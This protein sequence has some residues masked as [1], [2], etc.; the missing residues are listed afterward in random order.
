M[1]SRDHYPTLDGLRGLAALSVLL[2]HLGHWLGIR[3]IATNARLAVDLFFCLSGYVV[4][5]AYQS[6]LE[7]GMG[8]WQFWQLRVLRL[9]PMILA[10]TLVSAAY[11]VTRRVLLHDL[12]I[13]PGELAQA[14]VVSLLCLPFFTASRALGG[15]QVFPLNG[16]QYTLFL[17]LAANLVWSLSPRARGIS[18]A[19]AAVAA[20]FAL[21]AVFGPGGDERATFWHGFPRVFGSY[22]TGVLVFHLTRSTN[23]L[24]TALAN[25][26]S[27]LT[28]MGLTILVT[29]MIFYWPTPAPH[30][31]DLT[32][33]LIV[34]P[35]LVLGGRR[36]T[37][38]GRTRALALWLGDISYPLYALHYPIFVWLNA[39]FKQSIS[40]SEPM[41]EAGV[42]F[43]IIL[44]SSW[45]LMRYF[46][47]PM[48]QA[49]SGRLKRERR[50]REAAPRHGVVEGPSGPERNLSASPARNPPKRVEG[51]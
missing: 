23:P 15:P 38:Q 8:K 24:T 45:I 10:G 2:F 17:E 34:A 19:A 22:Y 30:W 20:S 21:I 4:P 41:V 50:W 25:R 26:A 49:L 1:Q 9:W 39:V 37:L 31:I 12:D 40:K 5:L 51:T 13:F 3:G 18:F 28:A 11:L 42:I 29:A 16:P 43:P 7:Q 35:L 44:A 46:D 48:R 47:E 6:R 36:V 27:S 14:T 33:S 32:W